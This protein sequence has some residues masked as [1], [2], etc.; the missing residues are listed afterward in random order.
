MYPLGTSDLCWQHAEQYLEMV[1]HLYNKLLLQ[2]NHLDKEN[3]IN[4][5]KRQE[6]FLLVSFYCRF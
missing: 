4:M 1:R 2:H 6:R 3:I 5:Y